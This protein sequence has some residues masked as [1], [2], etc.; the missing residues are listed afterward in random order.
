MLRGGGSTTTVDRRPEEITMS[1]SS[2]VR[3]AVADYAETH[4]TP[5]DE[6]QRALIEVT[7]EKTEGFSGMQIGPDQGAFMSVL[8]A[9]LQPSFAVEVGTFTGYSS[10]C[11]ARGLAPGGR[12]LCCDISEEWTAIAREHW[13]MAGVDGRIELVLA[14][15]V[16]TLSA[17]PAEPTIDF[18]FIDADKVGYRSYYEEIL[19]RL[20]PDGVI[21]FDNTLWFAQVL[22]DS[23][24]DDDDTEALRALNDFLVTDDRVDVAQLT[25]GDGIT[26]VRR[27][28]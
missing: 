18:A 21:L 23:G 17:L 6:V 5:P 9:T 16:E 1:R 22:P 14:P 8:V 2:F 12:L 15:A 26:M 11:I 13:A 28:D 3:D 27:R 19:P 24:A 20:S 4:S 25:L 7:K 10:L